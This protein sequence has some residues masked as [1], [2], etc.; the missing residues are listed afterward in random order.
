M[1]SLDEYGWNNF[2]QPQKINEDLIIGRITSIQGF[3][4]FVIT[5]SGEME[6]ELPEDCC[7][8]H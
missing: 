3:K 5:N 2:F 8:A 1:I 6:A 7:M 4:Y